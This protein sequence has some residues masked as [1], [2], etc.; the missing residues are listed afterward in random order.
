MRDRESYSQ[1][2]QLGYEKTKQQ[3]LAHCAKRKKTALEAFSKLNKRCPVC[4][5]AITYEARTNTY[6]SQRC[7]AIHNNTGVNRH[8]ARSVARCKLCGI[9]T[10]NPKFCTEAHAAQYRREQLFMTYEQTATIPCKSAAGTQQFLRRYALWKYPHACAICGHTVWRNQPIP[11]VL[12]HADGNAT[13]NAQTNLRLICGN[14]DMQLP[15]YKGR[16]R[17]HGRAYRRER[18]R[19]GKTC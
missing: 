12:D 17:G 9:D 8:P 7:A 14:C 13:N 3:L 15:T 6:C 1:A 10:V 16:N 18:Y 5:R 4:A 19:D 11:L 2:G